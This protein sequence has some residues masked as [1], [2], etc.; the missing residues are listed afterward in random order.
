MSSL[1]HLHFKTVIWNQVLTDQASEST[2]SCS[3]E[4]HL[5]LGPQVAQCQTPAPK[6][7]QVLA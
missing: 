3:Q 6:A 7:K 4:E 1:W 2:F 5:L